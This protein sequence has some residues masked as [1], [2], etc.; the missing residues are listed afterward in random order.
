[1][2]RERMTGGREEVRLYAPCHV[3]SQDTPPSVGKAYT[4][5]TCKWRAR[6]EGQ[7]SWE[8]ETDF[9]FPEI[10]MSKQRQSEENSS[11]RCS[12]PYTRSPPSRCHPSPFQVTEPGFP[13][14][15]A[16]QDIADRIKPEQISEILDQKKTHEETHERK[17]ER[18]RDRLEVRNKS[19]WSR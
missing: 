13:R 2:G 9:Y 4:Y 11:S 16:S 18:E 15:A 8:Q 12:R 1:M 10:D 19:T 6:K 14:Y 5:L 7:M 17:G 3:L